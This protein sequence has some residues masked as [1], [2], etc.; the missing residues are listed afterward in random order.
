MD[1]ANSKIFLENIAIFFEKLPF[2]PIKNFSLVQTEAEQLLERL[3]LFIKLYARITKNEGITA[4]EENQKNINPTK[5]KEG[6][7]QFFDAK[8]IENCLKK[9]RRL[10]EENQELSKKMNEQIKIINN[11]KHKET[12]TRRIHT[13]HLR[14]EVDLLKMKNQRLEAQLGI[15]ITDSSK[16]RTNKKRL[17]TPIISRS[18]EP[19]TKIAVEE[20]PILVKLRD[21]DDSEFHIRIIDIND[22]DCNDNKHDGLRVDESPSSKRQQ[23]EREL[24]FSI[25]ADQSKYI[26]PRFQHTMSAV[27]KIRKKNEPNR[28]EEILYTVQQMKEDN[29]ILRERIDRHNLKDS[30]VTGEGFIAEI[31]KDIVESLKDKETSL[32]E[33][34]EVK[35]QLSSLNLILNETREGRKPTIKF[36][37]FKLLTKEQNSSIKSCIKH[38]FKLNSKYNRSRSLISEYEE[39]LTQRL[40][41]LSAQ[42]SRHRDISLSQALQISPPPLLPS[43]PLPKKNVFKPPSPTS[44]VLSTKSIPRAPSPPLTSFQFNFNENDEMLNLLAAQ[45]SGIERLLEDGQEFEEIGKIN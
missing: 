14:R 18:A 5:F 20:N 21:G 29:K 17:R 35:N 39:L 34:L 43:K 24:N 31:K 2:V 40:S 28:L 8:F 26:T 37:Y 30:N 22:S 19:K 9:I 13:A 11:E 25:E 10:E 32:G 36:P 6:S 23:I 4:F 27:K 45:A 16:V 44:R 38:F 42:L 15:K 12:S 1:E 3:R 41:H 33:L 7:E